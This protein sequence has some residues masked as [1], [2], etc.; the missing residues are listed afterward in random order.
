VGYKLVGL[1]QL[2]AG[3][4]PD[5]FPSVAMLDWTTGQPNAKY[6]AVQMLATLG[7]GKK[8]LYRTELSGPSATAGSRLYGLGLETGGER[9][10]LLVSKTE[11]PQLVAVGGAGTTSTTVAL[12]LDGTVD[13]KTLSTEPGFLPPVARPLRADGALQLGP[14]GIALLTI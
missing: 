4:F 13:G 6:Y 3:P 9:K 10:L 2:V 5:N 11:Q 14:W 12:V 1:D 7:T 8:K